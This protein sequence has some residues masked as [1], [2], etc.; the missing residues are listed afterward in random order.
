MQIALKSLPD[1]EK[2]SIS[3]LPTETIRLEIA[4][5]E[6]I[7]KSSQA[8]MSVESPI[9][10][11]A[12]ADKVL[13]K[14]RNASIDVSGGKAVRADKTSVVNS[15]ANSQKANKGNFFIYPL[16]SQAW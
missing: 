5:V 1:F 7:A 14:L 8:C 10:V 12:I 3:Q 2:T 16:F 4:G 13:E 15:I 6:S 9:M 11:D